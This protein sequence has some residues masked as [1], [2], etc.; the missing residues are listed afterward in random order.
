[1]TASALRPGQRFG[2]YRILRRIATGGFATVYAARDRIEGIPVALKIPHAAEGDRVSLDMFQRE[3]RL[4]ARL[5][6]PNIL[7]IKTASLIDGVFVIVQPLGDETLGDR[8]R[9]RLST[10]R[11]LRYARQMLAAVACAHRER[12]LHGDIK[13]DNFILF[14]RDDRLRLADFGIARVAARTVPGSGTGTVG[15]CAP[16]QAMGRPSLRSDVFSLGLVLYR[17]FAGVLPEWPFPWPGPRAARLRRRIGEARAGVLRRAL[18]VDARERWAD[19]GALERAWTRAGR[20]AAR[21]RRRTAR[22]AV[23]GSPAWR[24]ARER[25]YLRLLGRG[26][27]RHRPCAACGGPVTESMSW[28]PWCRRDR[29]RLPPRE[30]PSRGPACPRCRRALKGSWRFCAWCWGGAVGP[31]HDRPSRD[32]RLVRACPERS[33][34]PGSTLPFSRYCPHCRR[35]IRRP[36]PLPGSRRRCRSCG[37][38]LAADHWEWCAWCG[39]SVRPQR[40]PGAREA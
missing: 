35:R 38:G 26:L 25:E 36:W 33:C 29:R 34:E 21:K 37:Q 8:L 20:K 14:R 2:Q 30:A 28:C 15:Y 27:G 16:E 31:V 17:M 5:E 7:P 9:R 18:A 19:A 1:M 6:H 40:R 24:K 23:T 22:K 12:I 32:R 13:P 3:V 10:D 4:V 39:V 11:A